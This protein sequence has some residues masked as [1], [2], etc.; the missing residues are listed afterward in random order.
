MFKI[1]HMQNINSKKAIS[2]FHAEVVSC[3][4]QENYGNTCFTATWT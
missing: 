2:V 1:R 3:L 4:L